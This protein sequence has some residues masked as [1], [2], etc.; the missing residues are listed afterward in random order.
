MHVLTY[1]AKTIC[2]TVSCVNYAFS[3]TAFKANGV[4]LLQISFS[5]DHIWVKSICIFTHSEILQRIAASEN[6]FII[7]GS[8]F[9][10]M[11]VFSGGLFGLIIQI[12][13]V[14]PSVKQFLAK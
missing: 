8:I 2:P 7:L 9:E 6:S 4:A 14:N 1:P 5:D 3:S 13:F 10:N 12:I 11:A